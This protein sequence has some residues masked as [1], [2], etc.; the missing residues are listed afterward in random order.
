MSNKQ[1][2]VLVFAIIF[3]GFIIGG[4]LIYAVQHIQID[5]TINAKVNHDGEIKEKQ[6][7]YGRYD[8]W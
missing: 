3:S 1:L 6:R 2:T 7:H 8:S 5:T 4:S